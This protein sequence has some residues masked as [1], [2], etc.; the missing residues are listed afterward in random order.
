MNRKALKRIPLEKLMDLKI[1][2]AFKQLFGSEKNKAI[3]VVFLNAILKR[4]GRD[5][6]KEITFKNVEIGGEYYGDKQSRLDLL[7]QTQDNQ[8][9][10]VEIQF[11]NK[12][13]MVKR[14][15]YYWSQLY[16]DQLIKSMSYIELNATITVNIL[17]FILF[18]KT[19]LF[20]TT[21]HLYE[22]EEKFRMD[23]M[24]EFHFIEI[25]KLLQHWK[26]ERLD[27]L[28]DVLARW[29]LLLGIVDHRK[30]QVYEDIYKELEEI[31]MKDEH[32][33]GA[34]TSWEELSSTPDGLL[35]YRTRL[36][37]VMDEEAAVKEAK[38]REQ[39]AL[40]KGV[41]QGTQTANEN[42][43]C[44]LLEMKMGIQDISKATGLSVEHV[45]SLKEKN[46]TE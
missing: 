12:Y 24:M 18:P 21:Y 27:P 41:E 39:V 11:T 17:N 36:K 1:D 20:H 28:N 40:E 35:A 42:T 14:S 44:N 16:S 45:A 19:D 30:G 32:L 38:I 4:T 7:V 6:V 33:L 43:A 5:N 2:Y 37:Q 22:D 15:I 46:G 34:F 8:Q 29:L 10:N 31:A 13:D 9:V 23:D 3:T 26:D 25:P